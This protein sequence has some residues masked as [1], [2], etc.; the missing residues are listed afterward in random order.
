MKCNPLVQAGG[1]PAGE[2]PV[3]QSSPAP[4][5]IHA[6]AVEGDGWRWNSMEEE[7]EWALK[8]SYKQL[9]ERTGVYALKS[10]EG[11]KK[12]INPMLEEWSCC[13]ILRGELVQNRGYEIPSFITSD[14]GRAFNISSQ[15]IVIEPSLNDRVCLLTF[16]HAVTTLEGFGRSGQTIQPR[17]VPTL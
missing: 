5:W 10:D 2:L 7:K 6:G 16:M 3:A 9:R 11:S 4:K 15:V 13:E 8:Y 14:E 1:R 17:I 12:V